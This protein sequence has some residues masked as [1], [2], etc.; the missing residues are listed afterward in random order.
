[1][2]TGDGDGTQSPLCQAT[3]RSVMASNPCCVVGWP[4]ECGFGRHR[5]KLKLVLSPDRWVI[6]CLLKACRKV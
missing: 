2:G 4:T 1:M 6:Y 5:V 3:W